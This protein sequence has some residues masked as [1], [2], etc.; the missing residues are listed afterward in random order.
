[1]F[2]CIWRAQKASRKMYHKQLLDFVSHNVLEA[3]QTTTVTYANDDKATR[4]RVQRSP[5]ISRSLF[6]I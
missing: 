3:I 2:K 6:S 5:D 4:L 1:M